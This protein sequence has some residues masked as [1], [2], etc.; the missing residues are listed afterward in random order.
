MHGSCTVQRTC[1]L[2]L[3]QG[4]PKGAGSDVLGPA[5]E[6]FLERA[7]GIEQNTHRIR[8]D[9]AD[10]TESR[11]SPSSHGKWLEAVKND[12]PPFRRLNNV[13]ITIPTMKCVG[14]DVG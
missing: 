1:F 10:F 4:T 9:S 3:C 5:P 7:T 11:N 12:L 14:W 6:Q 8:D 13:A 2:L